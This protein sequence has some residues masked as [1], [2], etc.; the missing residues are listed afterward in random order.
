MTLPQDHL[1]H[2]HDAFNVMRDSLSQHHI[3]D[4]GRG[5]NI[6]EKG[7]IGNWLIVATITVVAVIVFALEMSSDSSL[8]PTLTVANTAILVMQLVHHKTMET[9]HGLKVILGL[10]LIQGACAG[11]LIFQARQATTSGATTWGLIAGVFAAYIFGLSLYEHGMFQDMRVPPERVG[12][13]P[14]F[15]AT[16][17]AL[18]KAVDKGQEHLKKQMQ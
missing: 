9:D 10:T 6:T 3:A 18:L 16:I 5:Q 4:L 12:K 17:T 15:H 11:L 1:V 7:R 13:G 14:A 8:V 2:T